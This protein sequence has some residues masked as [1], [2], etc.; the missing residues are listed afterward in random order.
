M[1]FALTQEQEDLRARAA[2]FV[3]EELI[4]LE[5][6]CELSRGL[7]EE[8]L[9][10]VRRR[11]GELRL[12]GGSHAVEHGGQGWTMMEQVLAHEELGRNT[13][14]IWW[15][16]ANGYNVLSLGTPEQIE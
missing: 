7:P 3:D 8:T 15:A 1:D 11:A 14:A 6:E 5:V 2:R 9:A 10:H 13:N 12:N 4:P 16:M